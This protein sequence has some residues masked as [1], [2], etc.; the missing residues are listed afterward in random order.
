MFACGGLQRGDDNVT[1]VGVRNADRLR[2][3]DHTFR[4]AIRIG[5]VAAALR[6]IDLNIESTGEHRHLLLI[7]GVKTS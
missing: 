3:A 2:V 4:H 5:D 6:A 1:L 7:E